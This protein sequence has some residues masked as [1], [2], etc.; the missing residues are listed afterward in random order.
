MAYLIFIFSIYFNPNTT[1]T[2]THYQSD[3]P[4]VKN[5]IIIETSEIRDLK[6]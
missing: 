1:S 3:R 5:I 6:K 4:T 2:S